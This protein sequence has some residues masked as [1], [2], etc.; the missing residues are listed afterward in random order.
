MSHDR[1]MLVLRAVVENYIHTQE[2]VGSSAVTKNFPLHVSSAT[3]RNDMA[4]L[5]EE[6]YL[7]QPHTSAGRVPTEKGYRFFVDRLVR[8]VPL[9]AAQQRGIETFFTHSV[10]LEDTLRR[11]ARLLAQITGQVAI[12]ASPSIVKSHLRRFEM[13]SLSMNTYL[14]VII[15]DSGRVEQRTIATSMPPKP[16]DVDRLIA[17]VNTQNE[18][19]PISLLARKLK[20]IAQS[21]EFSAMRGFIEIVVKAVADMHD[22]ERSDSMYMSGTALLARGNGAPIASIGPLLDALE[23]QVVIMRLM[24]SLSRSANSQGVGVAIGSET[25]TQ[26]LLNASVVSSGYGQVSGMEKDAP[27]RTDDADDPDRSENTAPLAFVGSI[28]PTHMNYPT[29][30][31]AV[32]AVA[33]YLSAFINRQ[34]S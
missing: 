28:G 26:G 34:D 17:V 1:R 27:P 2:P 8:I 22:E 12:V 24:G 15:S 31:A 20:D 29:T 14:L 19:Q 13:V 11:A 4:A 5:E 18:G 23:E 30:I 33:E 21:D 25:H 7:V 32:K 10:S 3:I 9:S 6:G 16:D